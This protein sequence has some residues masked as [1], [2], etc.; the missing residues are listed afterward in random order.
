MSD[1]LKRVVQGKTAEVQAR[2]RRLPLNDLQAR[3][4][5]GPSPRDF[6]AALEAVPGVALIAE[7]KR[8]S[9]SAGLL[10][11]DLEPVALACIYQ[12]QGAAAVSVLTDPTFFRG[13]PAHLRRIR[14]AVGLPLLRKDFILHPYQV[15]EAR[16]WG[17]DA[18]LLIV[19]LLSRETLSEL[20][21]LA[22][23][24]GLTPLVEVHDEADLEQA[25]ALRPRLLGVNNRNLRTLKVDLGT[26]ERLR[27]FIPKTLPL[28]VESGIHTPEDVRWAARLGATAI[29]VGTALVRASSIPEKVRALV[30]AGTSVNRRR[31]PADRHPPTM[32]DGQRRA[33]DE[34]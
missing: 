9:P 29:L 15:Y 14:R 34:P 7:V 13:Y 22:L 11:P 24:L 25:L 19:A 20:H 10:A 1:F 28:V 21:D 2:M 16:L 12:A 17:A 32:T 30:D 27:P 8:A 23:H 3:V 6:V 26:T 5:D 18:V 31:P 4:Q 33:K